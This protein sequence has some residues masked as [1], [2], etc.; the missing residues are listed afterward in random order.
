LSFAGVVAALSAEA[1]TLGSSARRRDG[2]LA[3]HDGTLVALSGVGGAAAETAAQALVDAGASALVSWGMAGGLDPTLDA[4]TICLPEVVMS[5]SGDGFGTDL[6]WRELVGAAIATRLIVVGG[7]LVTDL[8][9]IEDVAGKA[10]AFRDTGAAAVDMES[11]NIAKV[12]ARRGLPFIAVRVIVDTAGDAIPA[13]VLAASRAGQ[14]R[15]G[16]L[17]QGLARS[18]MDIAPLIR[19]AQRYRTATRALAAVARSGA[20]A[21]L[22][23]A[24]TSGTRIA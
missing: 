10:A 3:T 4:G 5:R 23:F 8:T 12:A 17:M 21:P 19:L 6:H 24:A 11:F 16:Q 18:P 1:R 14:V 9:P 20:L 22:A 15:I 13:A 2:L 7:K